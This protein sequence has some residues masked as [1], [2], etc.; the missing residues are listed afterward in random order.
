MVMLFG[1]AGRT[2][3]KS[4]KYHY[5]TLAAVLDP[6]PVVLEHDVVDVVLKW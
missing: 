5:F 6:E 3:R 2:A 4:R 1:L